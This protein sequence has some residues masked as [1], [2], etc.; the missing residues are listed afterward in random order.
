MLRKDTAQA[1]DEYFRDIQEMMGKIGKKRMGLYL[2][3]PSSRHKP[4]LT[5]S[6]RCRKSRRGCNKDT[7]HSKALGGISR[8]TFQM[9]NPGLTQEQ[10]Y[11]SI[12]LIG[13]KK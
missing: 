7:P 11:K 10:V 3:D 1:K 8:F 5:R 9:D 2:P 6:L 12:E 13:K 4:G